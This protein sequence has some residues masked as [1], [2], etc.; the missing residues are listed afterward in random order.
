MLLTV[1]ITAIVFILLL[2]FVPHFDGIYTWLKP[3]S[4]KVTVGITLS[5][6]NDAVK[7]I[8]DALSDFIN[9][10]VQTMCPHKDEILGMIDLLPKPQTNCGNALCP[11]PDCNAQLNEAVAHFDASPLGKDPAAKASFLKL[12]SA[13][14]ASLCTDNHPDH[15]KLI[16]MMKAMVK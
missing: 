8:A 1:I 10:M 6:K 13:F 9:A 7:S 2:A 4:E 16:S 15:D 3:K 5:T 14:E 12:L 11:K